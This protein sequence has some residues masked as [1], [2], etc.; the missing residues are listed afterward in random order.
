MALISIFSYIVEGCDRMLR[1]LLLAILI[2]PALEIGVF[3]WLGGKIGP[4]WVVALIILTGF[5]G[6]TIAKKQGMDTW[7]RAQI[8][9]NNGVPPTNQII[10]GICVFAGGLFL[11][12]PGL[13]TDTIGFLF[14]LPPT[15]KPL[16][17]LIEAWIRRML[18]KNT[19][20]YR[21]W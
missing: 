1:W 9:M 6:V 12:S 8:Q 10:D 5:I 17:K 3:I 7:R 14:L 19:I 15:R 13:I 2:V 20:I 18:N 4:W 21:K 16:K 11:F